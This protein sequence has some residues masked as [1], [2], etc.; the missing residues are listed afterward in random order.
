M[1]ASLFEQTY[2]EVKK[3][4]PIIEKIYPRT[5]GK[6]TADIYVL[7]N[8]FNGKF[9][10]GSSDEGFSRVKDEHHRYLKRG[11]HING[12][13]QKSYSKWLKNTGKNPFKAFRI[14]IVDIENQYLAEQIALDKFFDGAKQC[15]NLV[16]TAGGGCPIFLWKKVSQVCMDTGK[17]L[18]VHPSFI[19]AER[20]TDINKVNISTCCLGK[21]NSAGGF[22]WEYATDDT[23]CFLPEDL[24]IIKA[25]PKYAVK[26]KK[27]SQ[28]CLETKNTIKVFESM[29]LAAR[30]L[31]LHQ[32][33]ISNCCNGNRKS[34]GG[35][36][37]QYT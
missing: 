35:Y 19:E 24:S 17:V 27:V 6:R 30:E 12:Y 26:L 5:E 23:K 11:T 28:V 32:G 9:Y 33:N 2:R 18:A 10:L 8:I 7:I 25:K 14:A 15:Y 34:H 1:P 21:K 20:V 29:S 13:L 36:L 37:W 16:P 3:L 31:G 4:A 22:H